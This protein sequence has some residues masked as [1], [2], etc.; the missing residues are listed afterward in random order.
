MLIVERV[1]EP[2]EHTHRSYHRYITGPCT[3]TGARM[4]ATLIWRHNEHD[5][6]QSHRRLDCLLNRLF[7]H[8]SKN[9][10]KLRV[11]GL[12]EENSPV[13]GEFP[14]QRVSDAENV[15][16]WWRHHGCGRVTRGRLFGI[17]RVTLPLSNSL[18]TKNYNHHMYK[19]TENKLL[20]NVIGL[21]TV[22]L[23]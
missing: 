12:C 5:G 19:V 9:A 15:S 16:I 23:R 6:V 3:N 4:K 18:R 7:R 13:T 17:I 14:T 20:R 1:K 11:T 10:S 8:R 21:T 2:M 22:N